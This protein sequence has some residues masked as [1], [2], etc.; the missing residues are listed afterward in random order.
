MQVELAVYE[1]MYTWIGWDGDDG[2]PA[3]YFDNVVLKI[4]DH[5]GPA[6]SAREVDLAQDDFPADGLIH[7]DAEMGLNDVRFD[8]A[9]NISLRAHLRNDPGDTIVADIVPVR[10]GAAFDGDPAAHPELGYKLLLQLIQL[11]QCLDA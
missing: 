11:P 5:Y 4:Y 2:Y 1:P 10:A 7:K 9:N 3:P 8:M 6:L